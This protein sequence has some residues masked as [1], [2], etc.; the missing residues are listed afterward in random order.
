MRQTDNEVHKLKPRLFHK[1]AHLR[2]YPADFHPGMNY[3][4]QYYQTSK[5]AVA[6]EQFCLLNPLL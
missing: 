5:S 3:V 1:S 6:S 2:V 4:W